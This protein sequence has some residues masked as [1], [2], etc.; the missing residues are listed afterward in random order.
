MPVFRRL[1]GRFKVMVLELEVTFQLA[2]EE[3][4]AMVRAGPVKELT[5]AIPPAA[6][7]QDVQATPDVAVE[8]ATKQRPSPPAI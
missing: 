3:E 1:L 8:E 6:A 5:E 4:V 7:E 2:E